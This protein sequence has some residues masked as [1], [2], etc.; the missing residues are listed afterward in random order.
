ML[1]LYESHDLADEIHWLMAKIDMKLGEFEESL[2]HLSTITESYGFDILGDDALYLTGKIYE[3]QLQD[4]DKAMEVYTQ[5]LKE[6]PGSVFIADVRKR[7]RN[8]RG[9]FNVN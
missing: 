7:V 1:N 4:K 3:E 6:H 9:D 2:A 5:F 8:L